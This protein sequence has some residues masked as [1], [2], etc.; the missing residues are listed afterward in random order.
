MRL[1]FSEIYQ[2]TLPRDLNIVKL[3]T[4]TDSLKQAK[5]LKGRKETQVTLLCLASLLL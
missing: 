5:G 1:Y 2:S 3:V 4:V